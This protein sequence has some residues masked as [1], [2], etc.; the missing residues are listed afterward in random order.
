V[1][2]TGLAGGRGG[3]M[4]HVYGFTALLRDDPAAH[5]CP[6]LLLSWH[7]SPLYPLMG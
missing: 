7:S 2:A 4:F 3:V 1:G 6:R 5:G